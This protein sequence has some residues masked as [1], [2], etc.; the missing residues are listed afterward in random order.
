LIKNTDV[1]L[2]KRVTYGLTNIDAPRVW[3]RKEGGVATELHTHAALCA[4]MA[5]RMAATRAP[6]NVVA[7]FFDVSLHG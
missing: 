7:K 3:V 2:L 5:A 6:T 1:N 4:D